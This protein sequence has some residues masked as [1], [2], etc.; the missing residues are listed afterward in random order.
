MYKI[1]KDA[2]IDQRIKGQ[3]KLLKTLII[4]IKISLPF[5]LGFATLIFLL[6]LGEGIFLGS[7]I[8]FPTFD[9]PEGVSS[10]VLVSSDSI[11]ILGILV[12][13][14]SKPTPW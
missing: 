13:L 10:L 3:E 9:T 12:V 2:N 6:K 7:Y 14:V 4:N 5:S 8:S 11:G 1:I